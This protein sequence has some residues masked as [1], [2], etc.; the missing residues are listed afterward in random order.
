MSWTNQI[1]QFMY[2][3]QVP[4]Q[5]MPPYQGYPF[6]GMQPIPPYYPATMQWPPNV[7]ESGH[8]LARELDHRRSRKSSSGKKEK[9]S[10][11]TPEEDRTEFTDSDSKTDSDADIQEDGKHSSTDSSYKKKHRRKST[12]TVVIR[13]INYI[14]SKRRDG[15]KDGISG[16]STSDE[17]EIIDGDALKQKVDEAVGSLEKIHKPNSRHHK[18]RGGDKNHIT[19]DKDLENEIA[20]DAP[21][22]EK[23]NDNWD[24][25]QN[26]LSIDD[27]STPNGV[28]EH[29]SADVHDEQFMIK[30]PED[31]V[32]FAVKH[33][34]ELESEKFRVQQRVASDSF[35]VT[36]RDGGNE[37][38]DTLEDF[39]NGENFHP[40]MRRRDSEIEEFLFPQRSKQS[41]TDI[42]G[43]L[44]DC[45]SESFTIK[46]G[47]SEDWFVAKHSGESK[48]HDATSERR[49]FNGDFSSSIADISSSEKCRKDAFIDDSFM[50][51]ARSSDDQY[52][53]EWRT[54]LSMDS[55]LN[56][57]SQTE[58]ISADKSLDKHG[59][60]GAYE[61]NDLC[62][63]LERNS[64]LE[65]GGASYNPEIDYGIDISFSETDKR[66]PAI[67]TNNLEDEKPLVSSNDKNTAD[68][69]AKNPAKEARPKA[70]GPLGKSKPELIYKSKKPSTISR[71]IVQKSKLEKVLMMILFHNSLM[72]FDCTFT[73]P[74]PP[75]PLL[76]H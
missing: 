45:T 36:E 32:S 37:V 67:E 54:D 30:T 3:F 39:Q 58:N 9:A 17:D 66:S 15:D 71:S 42:P 19:A 34:V 26:L 68:T 14:T 55:D 1:P 11:G 64:E 21:E 43:G 13:N 31:T 35:V 51:Q 40:S 8:P 52:Y 41:G 76:Y 2:N 59:V 63:V 48:N 22:V 73:V 33:A 70:R 60:S 25:F 16:E 65:S 47:N 50:V 57:V 12:R 27:E 56:V 28:G 5:Q 7:E 61:P 20:E 29:H 75:P 10:N 44:D 74:H 69:R 6:P 72:Q 62:M 38:S 24:T 23:G 4:M 53:S 18:K 46:R 49:I